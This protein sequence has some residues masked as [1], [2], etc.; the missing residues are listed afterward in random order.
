MIVSDYLSVKLDLYYARDSDC[1]LLIMSLCL[2]APLPIAMA[3]R[4]LQGFR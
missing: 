2:C 1:F 4:S 3:S